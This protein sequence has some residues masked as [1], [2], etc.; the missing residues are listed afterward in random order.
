[1]ACLYPAERETL[2][3]L[4]GGPSPDNPYTDCFA[5]AEIVGP[6]GSGRRTLATQACMALGRPLLE[7]D[8]IISAEPEG[9]ARLVRA[10]RTARLYGA[11]PCWRLADPPSPALWD[12]ATRL[13]SALIVCTETPMTFPAGASQS[14]HR[15]VLHRRTTLPALTADALRIVWQGLSDAPAPDVIG[16]WRL[17]PGDLVRAARAVPDGE[18]AV[19]AACG[20]DH[21]LGA[22]ELFVRLP[23]PYDWDDIVLPGQVRDH[24]REFEQQA[25]L[26]AEVYDDWG[27]SR[28]CP[29]GRGITAL[30]AGPSGTGKTMAA[31]VLARS[32]GLDLYRVDLAGVVNKYIGETEKRL[33]D[34]FA[35]A[36]RGNVLIFFDEADALFGQRSEVKEANDRF[37]NI[38][39][40]YLL[41]RMEQFDG[42]A[43]LATNRKNDL[44]SAFLRRL[45][46][47][48]DF[49][50]PGEA[51]R[52]RIWQ[53]VLPPRNLQ[54]EVLLADLDHAALAAKLS[55][56]GA[57]ITL[58][59][60]NA[61]FLARAEGERISMR[62]VLH[63]VAREHAKQGII[64]RQT[65]WRDA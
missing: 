63:A 24:L 28:L 15:M 57:E 35:I 52:L 65:E 18:A 51:E 23:C 59:A 4:L 46:H 56:T 47:V 31:Q 9:Q 48:V 44:D 27:F 64:L 14:A 33:R 62:H 26:R 54:G 39:I 36:E 10:L 16:R 13:A 3:A 61:A 53:R 11:V 32:L 20:G 55:L 2:H 58:A 5:I 1:M 29:L 60:L 38:E 6:E 19:L 42:V 49:M 37:A 7:I 25:R 30:F 41:Q 8:G 22:S 43:V 21:R 34:I 45:R 50:H 40:D 12:I 17:L